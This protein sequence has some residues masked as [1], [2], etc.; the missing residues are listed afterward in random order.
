MS[1]ARDIRRITDKGKMDL[2]NFAKALKVELF[3]SVVL[4]T[5]VDTGRLRG[6]WQIQDGERPIGVVDRLDRSGALV[7]REIEGGA[8][9]SGITYFVNNLPYAPVW[10]R[11]DA[12]VGRSVSRLRSVVRK[13]AR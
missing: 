3:S 5:R 8:S 6:N 7:S 1:W 2:G 12:M 10:E 4:N 11:N 13:L 9:R